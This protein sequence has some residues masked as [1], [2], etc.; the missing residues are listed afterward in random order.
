LLSHEDFRRKAN[1]KIMRE[2]NSKNKK[3]ELRMKK[4]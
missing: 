1:E 3:R 4:K 2:Q